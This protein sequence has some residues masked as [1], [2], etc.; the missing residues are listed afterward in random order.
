MV[1]PSSLAHLATYIGSAGGDGRGGDGGGGVGWAG[2]TRII[3][4]GWGGGGETTKEI[5]R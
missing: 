1:Y 2:D 3:E 5:T 4:C